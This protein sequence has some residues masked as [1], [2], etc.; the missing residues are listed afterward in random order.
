M[1]SDLE[2]QKMRKEKRRHDALS[3]DAGRIALELNKS[4]RSGQEV[5][6]MLKPW[7]E[8]AKTPEFPIKESPDPVREALKAAGY[9]D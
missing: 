5:A 2:L 7:T 9:I 3:T 1:L 4:K 6:E 8:G